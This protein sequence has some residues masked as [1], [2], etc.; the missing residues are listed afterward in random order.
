[1]YGLFD[2]ASIDV[3]VMVALDTGDTAYLG[4]PGQLFAT[5]LPLVVVFVV[6]GVFN[7]FYIIVLKKLKSDSSVLRPPC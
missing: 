6:V 1:M 3:S 7:C 4:L 2:L 5:Y